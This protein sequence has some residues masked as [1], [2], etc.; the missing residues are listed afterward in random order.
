LKFV[1]SPASTEQQ[2][3][4][5]RKHT[6]RSEA[7]TSQEPA[8]LVEHFF[9][10]EYGRLVAALTN[11]LG[12]RKIDLAEDVAQSALT[13]ALQHWARTGIPDNP[14]GW[15]FQVATRLAIDT[16]RRESMASR[17]LAEIHSELASNSQSN[18][19]AES[20]NL[21]E[22]NVHDDQFQLLMACCHPELPQASSIALALKVLCG[23]SVPEIA[24]GLLT[25][26]ANI[27]K[28]ITRAKEKL[29]ENS[30]TLAPTDS[31]SWS[32]RLESAMMVIYLMF[33]EGY[34]S[35]HTEV[36]IRREL[37]NEARRLA[38]ILIGHETH[39][40]PAVC[41]LLS[42]MSFHSA[43]LDTRTNSSGDV[44]LLEHQDRS[45]W[46]WSLIREGMD[47]MQRSAEGATLSRYHIEAAI[48]W[49]HCRAQDF[50]STD[51]QKICGLYDLLLARIASPIQWLNRAIAES[52]CNGPRA[53]LKMLEQL[54]EEVQPKNY[55]LW[56]AVLGHLHHRDG[57]T[58]AA[59]QHWQQA[60]SCTHSRAEQELLRRRIA[61]CP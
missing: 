43:R 6:L 30:V 41:A 59:K 24:H 57:N 38:R 50:E 34:L 31:H 18:K 61:A 14:G 45:R 35:S 42:L 51:W 58:Q 28:R 4:H 56:S 17:K 55:P 29:S 2:D 46:D 1:N 40:A 52:F 25:S 27:Q 23:F 12:L 49:E 15:L 7:G 44:L 8:T 60:L 16:M 37:C 5:S 26:Q 3:S 11:K 20:W 36:S 10:H 53:A 33:N 22:A 13:Q 48:A 54:P 47:W 32:D 39:T 21:S 19:V 9:R